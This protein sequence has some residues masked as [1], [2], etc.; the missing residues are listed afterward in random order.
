MA[1]AY[2]H[3]GGF[4][5]QDKSGTPSLAVLSIAYR[6]SFGRSPRG[7]IALSFPFLSGGARAGIEGEAERALLAVKYDEVAQIPPAVSAHLLPLLKEYQREV[8]GRLG[9]ANDVAEIR[10]KMTRTARA[11]YGSVPDDGWHAYCL[12]DLVYACE[13][14]VGEQTNVEIVW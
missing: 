7:R 4:E 9:V 11:K 14:S 5:G 2:I 8:L 3:C 1:G 10:P 12:H 13:K 6:R